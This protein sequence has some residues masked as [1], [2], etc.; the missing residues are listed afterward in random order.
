MHLKFSQQNSDTLVSLNQE[1]A[2]TGQNMKPISN[3]KLKSEH[4]CSYCTVSLYGCINTD[5]T[6]IWFICTARSNSVSVSLYR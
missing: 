6:D 1:T 3:L 2:V 4:M 5:V